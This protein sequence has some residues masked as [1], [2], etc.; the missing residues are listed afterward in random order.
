MIYLSHKYD[1]ALRDHLSHITLI[2]GNQ[3]KVLA[4]MNKLLTY[5]FPEG[6]GSVH[7]D[8]NDTQQATF[9]DSRL[10][11]KYLKKVVIK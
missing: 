2:F 7:C 6:Y 9:T 1:K 10:L 5:D 4:D 8:I 11:E 3:P